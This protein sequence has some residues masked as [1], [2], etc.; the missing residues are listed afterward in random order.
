MGLSL[1]AAGI[2]ILVAA[3]FYLKSTE[4][5]ERLAVRLNGVYRV[6]VRKYYVDEFLDW[7]IVNPIRSGSEKVLWKGMDA[8]VIDS[9][10]VE[11]AAEA[12]SGI[13]GVLRRIQSGNIRSYAAWVVLGAVVWLIYALWQR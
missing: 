4:I 11:G 1:L 8:G 7:L 3:W 12:A 9:G 10:L 5:P 13:G 2:G 6:L